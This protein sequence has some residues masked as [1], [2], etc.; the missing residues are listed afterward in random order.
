[1]SQEEAAKRME[2]SRGTVWRLLDSGRRKV[3]AM[4]VEHKELMVRG[5]G[6]HRNG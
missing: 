3:V 5:K 2:V 4:M 1:L 6:I